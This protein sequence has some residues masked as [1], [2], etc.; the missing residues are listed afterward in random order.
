MYGA[1]DPFDF[2]QNGVGYNAE[3]ANA[4]RSGVFYH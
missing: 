4:Y 3:G 1:I 2:P